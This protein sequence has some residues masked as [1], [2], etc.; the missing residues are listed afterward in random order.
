MAVLK[1]NQQVA[2][3]EKNT[4]VL[5][6]AI[7]CDEIDLHT[8]PAVTKPQDQDLLDSS[9]STLTTVMDFSVNSILIPVTPVRRR[10]PMLSDETM[11]PA[12]LLL[13]GDETIESK[14]SISIA[15]SKRQD[16]E[17]Q[18]HS[19]SSKHNSKH[20]GSRQ[21]QEKRKAKRYER[22]ALRGEM[23]YQHWF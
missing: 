15:P 1:M 7:P 8:L 14:A 23:A 17:K 3:I 9:S 16:C 5:K 13:D 11:F 19:S 10:I 21:T 12:Y 2:E 20:E 22:K 18:N 6:D 4:S